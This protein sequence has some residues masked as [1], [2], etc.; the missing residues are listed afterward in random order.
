[1]TTNVHQTLFQHPNL[2]W[3]QWDYIQ[4]TSLNIDWT[5][6]NTIIHAAAPRNLFKF[7]DNAHS[8]YTILLDA[9]HYLLQESVKHNIDNFNLISTGDVIGHPEPQTESSHYYNP[10]SFYGAIKASAEL[11]T[12][13]YQ[14]SIKTK[15]L[16]VFHPYGHGGNRFL[17]NRMIQK[18]ATHDPITIEGQNGIQLN[19]IWIEDLVKGIGLASE[20]PGSDTFHL[21]GLET[22]HL[23]ALLERI[24][25]LLN[26]PV[27]IHNT[28]SK[29]S[30]AHAGINNKTYQ[31]LN[32]QPEVKIN[33]GLQELISSMVKA[34]S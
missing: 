11:I 28:D 9:T 29:P 12:K 18:I 21:G 16:R 32:W 17:V 13:S 2:T 8:I 34:N 33:D 30:F 31:T 26:I 20:Y 23:K 15:I 24:A 22:I 3:I 25:M 10:H 19:P 4:K 1:M 6:I 5:T 7:P 14:S 27:T